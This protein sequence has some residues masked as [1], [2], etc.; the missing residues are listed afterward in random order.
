MNESHDER[1]VKSVRRSERGVYVTWFVFLLPL[2]LAAMGLAIDMAHYRMAHSQLQNAADAAALAGAKSLNGLS[3]GRTQ[4]AVIATTYAKTHAVDG[5]H[6]L[7][8]DVLQKETGTWS[9]QSNVYTASGTKD[10]TAN[11]LRVTLKRDDVPSYFSAILSGSLES[12]S[13]TATS[14]AVAG[15]AGQVPCAAPLTLAAC[16]LQYDSSGGLVCPSSLTFQSGATSVGLT[17]PDGSSPANGNNAKPFFQEVVASPLTCNSPLSFGQSLY[18]SN[19]N[20]LA[21]TSVNDINSATN[22]GA[23]PVEIVVPITD[24]PC[25]SN[26][27]PNYNGTAT[28]V[29]FIKMNLVGARWNNAAAPKIAEA[30]PNIGQKNVCIKRNCSIITGT[31][32]GG[33]VQADPIRVYLIR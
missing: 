12:R 14:T 1:R 25:G 3:S 31:A 7:D 30:C 22:N 2:L 15:G 24:A 33:T 26:G 5:E 6:L 23:N 10:I 9:P 16:T 4:S 8:T 19:G 11:A 21:Q 32:G 29:G 13:F 28:V 18:L 27:A 17:V 20:D